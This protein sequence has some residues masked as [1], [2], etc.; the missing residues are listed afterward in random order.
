MD[1]I[2]IT[3]DTIQ[4]EHICCSLSDKR[5]ESGV[6]LKKE[7][8]SNRFPEGLKFVRLN[9]RGKVF[10]EFLPA[11]NAWI[12]IDAPGY[13][14]VN[15]HWV[16]GR[17]KGQG[18]GKTLLAECEKAARNMHGIVV[19]SSN[20]KKPYL[21]DK[22]FLMKNGF[23][24]CDTAPPYFELLVKKFHPSYPDPRFRPNAKTLKINAGSGIDIYYTAQCPFA[25]NYAQAAL[26]AFQDSSQPVRIHQITCRQDAQNHSCP[27][28]S[29]SIFLNGEF[30]THEIL[31]PA[32]LL[33]LLKK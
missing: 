23:T 12:P 30:I 9:E 15:C 22:G 26:L 17:F 33:A 29:Y 28:T 8:L 32:K 7:W 18:W 13:M 10:I 1:I 27:V 6:Y 4:Q 21:S 11:E 14:A 5:T 20:K 16:A 25:V 2:H 19:I 24:V 3:K 31:T